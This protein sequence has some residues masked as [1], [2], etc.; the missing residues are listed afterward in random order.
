MLSRSRSWPLAAFLLMGLSACAGSE[1]PVSTGTAG[2]QSGNAG[3]P[4]GGTG[5]G[6][7][8]DHRQRGLGCGRDSGKHD[9]RGWLVRRKQRRRQRNRRGRAP[10]AAQRPAP[11]ARAAHPGRGETTGGRR[12]RPGRGGTTAARGAAE[13]PAPPARLRERPAAPGRPGTRRGGA[14]L[15]ERDEQGELRHVA[16][17]EPRPHHPA[18]AAGARR[19][20]SRTRRQRW[21]DA[22]Q[23]AHRRLERSV[24]LPQVQG[25]G[26][27]AGGRVRAR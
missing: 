17:A 18:S 11:R 21:P 12:E 10:P 13:P 2:N 20:I 27:P 23:S 7:A 3:N 24:E 9:R 16:G 25:P 22:G 15:A 4:G 26:R 5:G 6:N 19:W 8:A 1:V 14:D